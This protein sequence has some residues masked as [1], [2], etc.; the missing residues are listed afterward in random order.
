M[1]GKIGIFVRNEKDYEI[2]LSV[3]KEAI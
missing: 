1:S 2:L 3:A